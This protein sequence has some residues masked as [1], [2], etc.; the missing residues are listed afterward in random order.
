M[1]AKDLTTSNVS[2]Q[3]ILNNHVAL[4]QVETHLDLGGVHW[5]DEAIFTK[6]QVA[7]ILDVDERTIDRYI[8]SNHEELKQNGY[9]ILRGKILKDLKESFGD[10]INVATK[11]TV[12]GIFSFKA[13]LN[14]AMLV[15]ESYKAKQIR[16]KI[17]DIVLDVIAQKSGGH[18]KYINQRDETYLPAAY[19]EYNY[20]KEF[21]DALNH[22]LDSNKWKYS[23]YTNKIYEV[24]FLE[25]A[26]EYKKVLALKETDKVRET[27]YAE[28]LNAIASFEHGLAVEMK[29]A[30]QSLG[31]K[32]TTIELD[33][34]IEKAA[35]NPYLLPHIHD[36]RVKMASRDLCFRDA[37]HQKLESYIQS[38]PQS[39]F[40]KF[41]GETSK[42][43]EDRLSDPETLAVL[44]RL[45]DR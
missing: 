13:V 6:A 41:L 23:L 27:M 2:R 34:I 15:T 24:V 20:R 8:E 43:L 33:A 9:Q 26:A 31:R 44:K 3:N 14:L 5:Q 29:E 18:T 7:E 21:T 1:M 4:E 36:A 37:L 17:L 11:T 22:Y 39:D 45:K 40:D 16:S 30:S 42:S 38:V 19:K 32:L 12:L 28:V 25:K 10:D 35:K